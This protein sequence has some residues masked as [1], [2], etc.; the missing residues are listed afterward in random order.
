M[1]LLLQ[2]A[3]GCLHSRKQTYQALK[4]MVA[5]LGDRYTQF[6][7]P[8]QVPAVCC[9][10]ELC[11]NDSMN[12]CFKIFNLYTPGVTYPASLFEGC[13]KVLNYF[14]GCRCSSGRSCGGRNRPSATTWKL[15]LPGWASSLEDMPGNFTAYSYSTAHIPPNFLYTRL[16]GVLTSPKSKAL[17]ILWNT[18]CSISNLIGLVQNAD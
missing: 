5:T 17:E 15:C 8:A 14:C 11:T 2:E 1:D 16:W 12:P 9:G 6:L 18:Q 3:G 7:G 13:A 4:L 10:Q